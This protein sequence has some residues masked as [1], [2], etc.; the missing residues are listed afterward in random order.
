VTTPV[1][2]KLTVSTKDCCLTTDIWRA[3]I[4]KVG[5]SGAHSK[6][7]NGSIT[8]YSGEAKKGIQPGKIYR[9]LI[10]A[11]SNSGGFAAG[12]E[13]CFEGPPGFSVIPQ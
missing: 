7:G 3:T 5:S 8:N 12:L 13:V 11:D 9:V 2:G 10:N 6:I 1:S 4:T